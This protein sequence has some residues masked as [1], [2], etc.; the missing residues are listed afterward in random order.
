MPQGK[1]GGK[2]KKKGKKN[3]RQWSREVLT[4]DKILAEQD[5]AGLKEGD[6]SYAQI[7]RILSGDRIEVHRFDDK[8]NKETINVYV[9][10][11]LRKPKSKAVKGDYLLVQKRSFENQYDAIHFYTNDDSKMLIKWNEVP[12]EESSFISFHNNEKDTVLTAEQKKEIRRK[13]NQGG[14]YLDMDAMFET[15]PAEGSIF[16]QFEEGTEEENKLVKDAVEFINNDDND[17]SDDSDD[18]SDS[19]HLDIDVEDD[20][21]SE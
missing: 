9:T 15:G 4:K 7:K 19:E 18:E 2:G 11:R 13:K 16:S 3:P 21:E 12:R 14:T 6:I 5:R 20:Y 17:D 10:K 1:K 8:N